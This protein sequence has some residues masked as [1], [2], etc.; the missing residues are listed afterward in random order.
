MKPRS[1]MAFL[2]YSVCT[3]AMQFP[4]MSCKM[5]MSDIDH[6]NENEITNEKSNEINW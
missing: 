3:A 6:K 1:F 2:F 5:N 4:K